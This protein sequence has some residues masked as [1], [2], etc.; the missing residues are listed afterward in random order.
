MK[1]VHPMTQT[2]P[3]PRI[4][5]D[6]LI[7]SAVALALGFAL[8]GCAEKP[9]EG[10]NTQAEAMAT[11]EGLKEPQPKGDSAA[12]RGAAAAE[13]IAARNACMKAVLGQADKKVSDPNEDLARLRELAE[14]EDADKA[15]TKARS[16]SFSEAASEGARAPIKE[17]KY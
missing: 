11:C 14:K 3:T 13:G 2:Q 10:A 15:A 12:A 17:Y 5:K 16:K 6:T 4:S 8:I 7:K 1:G 9:E